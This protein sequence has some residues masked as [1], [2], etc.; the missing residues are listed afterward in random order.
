MKRLHIVGAGP[1]TGTTLMAEAMIACF[2]IDVYTDHEDRIYAQPPHDGKIFLTKAP[3]DILVVSPLLR[4]LSN[5][6]VIYMLRDP[7]D[8]ITS[9]HR[10]NP[11][12]YWASLWFWHTYTTFGRKLQEHPRF[13]TIRYEDLVGDPDGTQRILMERM[14]FLIK[15]VTFS[16]F[17]EVT[18][19]SAASE[20]ALG[21][22]RSI[23]PASI[24]NWRNHLP[25][26]AGQLRLHKP[27][28]QDLIEFGYENDDLWLREL[29]KVD[30]DIRESHWP[31]YYT[32]VELTRW[33][34]K[35]Y[36]QVIKQIIKVQLLRCGI[37]PSRLKQFIPWRTSA[38]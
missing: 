25:R 11:D 37:E 22:V 5:L 32:K 38:K 1:R 34:L 10:K 23:S 3:E 36:M 14:P 31:E 4:V 15:K 9:K 20:K 35:S 16:R 6:Y 8:T 26:V 27:I 29:D 24:G 33:Q 13:I 2:E 12:R 18:D 7:R 19:P 28:T 30:P 17:H 21:G